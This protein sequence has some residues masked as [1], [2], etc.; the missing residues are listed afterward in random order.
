MSFCCQRG[1]SGSVCSRAARR[2]RCGGPLR[3]VLVLGLQGGD[4]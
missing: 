4:I 2:L 1:K 3:G